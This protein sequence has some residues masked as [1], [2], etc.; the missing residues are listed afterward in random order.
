[1]QWGFHDHGTLSGVGAGSF[2]TLSVLHSNQTSGLAISVNLTMCNTT[3]D[4]SVTLRGPKWISDLFA[5]FEKR[6]H[7]QIN[8]QI[9]AKVCAFLAKVDSVYITD[10]IQ[11]VNAELI[12]FIAPPPPTIPPLPSNV[13]LSNLVNNSVVNLIEF[14]VQRV[15]GPEGLNTALNIIN[16]SSLE[17]DFS[18]HQIS[19]PILGAKREGKKEH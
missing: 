4:V 14:F 16:I 9:D 18:A 2:D 11:D 19:F 15:L 3:A 17:F 8:D 12:G 1:L 5:F 13:T 10:V 6:F 7:K